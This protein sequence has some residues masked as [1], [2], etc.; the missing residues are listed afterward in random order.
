M[1]SIANVKLSVGA[2][3]VDPRLVAEINQHLD[4]YE[5]MTR[6]LKPLIGLLR[7]PSG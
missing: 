2:A 1:A 3:G 5:D 6:Y 4:V 7:D